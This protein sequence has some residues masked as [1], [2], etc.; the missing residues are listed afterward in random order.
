MNSINLLT[1][2]ENNKLYGE[3]LTPIEIFNKIIFPHIK[4]VLYDYL[5]VD[6]YAGK[7]NLIFPILDRIPLY[8]RVEFFKKHIRLFD[9]QE[10]MINFMRNKAINEYS[11]PPEIAYENIQLKDNLESFPTELKKSNFPIYHITNPPYLYIGYIKK[12]QKDNK[13]KNYL[14][15]F[16]GNRAK[17]QDLYQIALYNDLEADI[18]KMI[19]II[20]TNFI[21]GKSGAN[22]IRKTFLPYYDIKKA[23][24][25]EDKIFEN[26]GINVGIFF[27]SRKLSISYNP[28]I[29][30]ATK[31]RNDKSFTKTIILKKEYNFIAGNEF[32]EYARKNKKDN[33]K[34][35][36]YLMKEK[37]IKNKGKNQVI[38]LN[39]NKYNKSKNKYEKETYFVNDYLYRKIKDNILWIRTIDT[40]SYNGRA[41][42]YLIQKLGVDGIITE[43]P[44]RTHPIQIFFEPELTIKQQLT[45]KDKFNRQLELL[46]EKTDS[47]FM[48]TYKYSNSK[49]VRKYL[50]L[51]QVK[52]IISTI[53][54]SFSNPKR[55]LIEWTKD[56]H[57]PEEHH[58]KHT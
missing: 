28:I 26:T 3:Y 2:E 50:G 56:G 10:K 48:T 13:Y 17:L 52:K 1:K 4:D 38:L 36:F 23:Y 9:I 45:L 47:E 21:Y 15:Y 27:F 6:L 39:A 20:P 19:Y 51:T 12:H 35:L 8:E 33:P 49:Y 58:P 25:I 18:S 5:W 16:K 55:N 40:G 32:E 14:S 24:L 7:G 54:I 29:F 41:G 57:L 46:R 22:E 31:T 53:E 43:K 11:I 42:L 34:V 30:N 37:V 44:Y